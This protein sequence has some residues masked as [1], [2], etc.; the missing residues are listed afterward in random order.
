[1]RL[2]QDPPSEAEI[3][4]RRQEQV[5]KWKELEQEEAYR[6]AQGPSTKVAP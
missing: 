6:K 3:E 2:D 4:R 1:M 5:R